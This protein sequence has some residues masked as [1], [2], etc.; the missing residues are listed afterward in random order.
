[1]SHPSGYPLFSLLGHAM[2][3]LPVGPIPFRV[4]LLSVLAGAGTAVFVF[5]TAL[6]LTRDR[7]AA[8]VA[9]LLLAVHPLMWEWSLVAEVF[10]LNAFLASVE[11]Y[12]LI[13]WDARPS[14]AR[15]F[16]VAA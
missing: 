11:I 4:N 9:A 8:V 2:T 16:V 15:W 10:A 12:V 13:R 5:L 14:D 7:L 1:V 3:W 6:R